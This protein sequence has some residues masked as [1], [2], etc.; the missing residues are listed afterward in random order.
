MLIKRRAQTLLETVIAAG[1]IVVSVIGSTTLI[2]STMTVGRLS[3]SRVEAGN[4]AREGL[5]II[6]GI[7]D[8]NW[9]QREQNIA[10]GASGTVQWD[11][12]GQSTGYVSLGGSGT[13]KCWR[14]DFDP[15]VG[16]SIVTVACPAG[17]MI[18]TDCLAD[19]PRVYRYD[20]GSG[21]RHYTDTDC[22]ADCAPTIFRRNVAVALQTEAVTGIPNPV[23]YLQVVSTICW[24]DRVSHKPVIVE[25][26]LYDWR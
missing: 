21:N 1:V 4:F 2:I 23:P 7:R 14:P 20:D 24:D 19:A 22:G 6:R 16:W 26:R 17:G 11:D 5:E 12:S 8:S 3:Q 25:E 15:T 13:P 9:L 10:D 18:P